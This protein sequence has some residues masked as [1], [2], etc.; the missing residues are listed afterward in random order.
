MKRRLISVIIALTMAV[1]TA[2][3]MTTAQA[4]AA[5]PSSDRGTV[6]PNVDPATIAAAV[7]A[8]YQAYQSFFGGG[9]SLQAAVD[10]IL[11]AI[12]SAQTA[13]ISHI[14]AIAA[15]E[16]RA[17]TRDAIVDFPNF[18]FLTPDNQQV[19]AL[20]ATSCANLIDSLLAT[21]V[22]KGAQDQL[23]FSVNA[24][25]PIALITRSRAGLPNT[26]FVPVLRSANQRVS[27]N[28]TPGC[29]LINDPDFHG[30]VWFCLAY[31]GNF[32]EDLNKVKAQNVAATNTSWPVANGVLTQLAGL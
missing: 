9:I 11:A 25:G 29:S 22:D 31:D 18:Q 6:H 4:S 26:T 23:G 17:C 21:V 20:H 10:K 2:L 15:A 30:K 24:L 14:D 5:T 3:G 32:F 16:A 28:L 13:I 27:T 19:F 1:T 12:Q 7:K 8:A